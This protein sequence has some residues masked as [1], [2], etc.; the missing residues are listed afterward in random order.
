MSFGVGC[1]CGSDPE[2]LWLWRRLAAVALNGLGTS[3]YHGWGPGKY[4]KA[5]K[6]K[7]IEIKKR[8][9]K[10]IYKTYISHHKKK[11]CIYV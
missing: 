8:K 7:R 11:E 5:K 10:K 6:K 4:K 1:R 2:L 9:E 3:I